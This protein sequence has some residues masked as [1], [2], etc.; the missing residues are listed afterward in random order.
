MKFSRRNPRPTHWLGQVSLPLLVCVVFCLALSWTFVLISFP[1]SM[2]T[3]PKTSSLPMSAIDDG[4]DEFVANS[5]N[6]QNR[7]LSKNNTIDGI[8]AAESSFANDE[9]PSVRST[10]TPR[11]SPEFHTSQLNQTAPLSSFIYPLHAK[12][13]THH[14]YLYVGTPPQRQTLIVDTGSR[15]TAFPCHPHCSDC[16]KHA[17]EPF[18]LNESST[19]TIVSCDECRLNQV[20]F[21]QDTNYFSEDGIVGNIGLGRN[22][23]RGGKKKLEER[24][25]R[26]RA[27]FP[28]SCQCDIDQK[29]TEGS[30]WKAFEVKDRVWLGLD[31]VV[32]SAEEFV[33][34]CQV[35]EKGLFKSQYAGNISSRMSL[36]FSF[37]K[38]RMFF[39]FTPFPP[40][41]P[42]ADGIMGLS[43]YT[44]MLVGVFSRHGSIPHK[45]FS[46][47]L[48]RVGGH[49]SL[50]GT[51]LTY[52]RASELE[53]EA[54]NGG[55]LLA[56]MKFTPFAN[57]NVWYYT[58]TVTSISVG[59]EALPNSILQYVNDHKGTIIDSGTT[60]TFISHK[61]KDVSSQT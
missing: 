18:Y 60:D 13:G 35:S 9:H 17:S 61:L 21:Q 59:T 26:R 49:I 43:M 57:L 56:P 7:H 23:L 14:A 15:L 24:S 16:G 3:T 20:D 19:H 30:S 54:A 29:Y 42:H 46:L 34:G 31:K 32:S 36:F 4:Q 10:Q 25:L 50:G 2:H 37:I 53:E 22:S 58:V 51:G 44:Q 52:D 48:N 41:P 12:S 27:S 1:L 39:I 11:T 28:K 55:R 8:P 47:C 40:D 38:L 6:R 33:F 45:S 5:S